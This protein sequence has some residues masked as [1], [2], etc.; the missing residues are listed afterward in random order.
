ME[1]LFYLSVQDKEVGF[2]VNSNR[3]LSHAKRDNFQV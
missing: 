2:T 1:F 3:F